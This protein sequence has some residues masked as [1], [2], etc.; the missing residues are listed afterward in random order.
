MHL[1]GVQGLRGEAAIG[2][3]DHI[4]AP[5]Q[6]GETHD[7][8]GDQFGMFD[9]IAGVRN[10]AGDENFVFWHLYVLEQMIFVLVARIGRLETIRAGIDLQHVVDD[11][12][13]RR[14]MDARAFVDAVAG[15]EAHPFGRNA[16]ERRIG[17]L[18]VDLGA[19]FFLLIVEAELVKEVRQE[20]IVD[21]HQNAGIIDRAVFLAHRRGERVKDTPRLTCNTR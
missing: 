6:F 16:L 11:F 4:L 18:D 1:G 3:G 20:W 17:R 5:H 19:A 14:F 13:E 9:N 15:V 12:A 7:A 8:F 10:D 2:A 21:L